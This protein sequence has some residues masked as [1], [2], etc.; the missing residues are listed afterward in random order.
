MLGTIFS[1][2]FIVNLLFFGIVTGII[3]RILGAYS[4]FEGGTAG[5]I[6]YIISTIGIG[7]LVSITGPLG[8]T[9]TLAIL[10]GVSTYVVMHFTDLDV[11][12]SIIVAVGASY[13]TPFVFSLVFSFLRYI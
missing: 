12:K 9:I 4:L 6:N 7:L 2:M 10:Y 13:L 8:P 11:I 1:T 5:A 3:A